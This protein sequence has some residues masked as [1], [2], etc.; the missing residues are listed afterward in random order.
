MPA[1]I[2]KAQQPVRDSF[3]LGLLKGLFLGTL[4]FVLTAVFM[5]EAQTTVAEQETRQERLAEANLPLPAGSEFARPNDDLPQAPVGIRAERLGPADAPAAPAPRPEVTPAART[6]PAPKPTAV[7]EGPR[8]TVDESKEGG[9]S[10][11]APDKPVLSPEVVRPSPPVLKP[12]LAEP[13]PV[14][15]AVVVVSS[16]AAETAAETAAQPQDAGDVWFPIPPAI[17]S[18]LA[19]AP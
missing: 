3:L 8:I 2:T 6:E 4:A 12:A 11:G 14:P 15:P 16:P 9:P 18:L 13:S 5:P 17:D 1:Q 19:N 7:A 10:G